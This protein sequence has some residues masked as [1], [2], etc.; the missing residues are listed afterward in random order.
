[1][2]T[3]LLALTA[4]ACTSGPGAGLRFQYGPFR[5][6]DELFPA[7]EQVKILVDGNEFTTPPCAQLDLHTL[8]PGAHAWSATAL[9]EGQTALYE[10]S[11]T[12]LV[13]QGRAASELLALAP[14]PEA[15]GTLT[16][17][18]ELPAR[19][20]ESCVYFLVAPTR[21]EL[22]LDGAQ[23]PAGICQERREVSLPTGLHTLEARVF[24]AAERLLLS[25]ARRVELLPGVNQP[26][27]VETESHVGQALVRWRLVEG[28]VERTCGQWSSER[29]VVSIVGENT[30]WEGLCES[31]QVRSPL[32]PPGDYELVLT[33]A[34]ATGRGAVHLERGRY[35]TEVS[36]DVVR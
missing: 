30:S 4:C 20:G 2:R 32:L 36:I 24:D 35:D 3:F 1:M 8:N 11:G 29:V 17:S 10:G 31:G 5:C 27:S 19:F 18:W 9:G 28:G 23:V 15:P 25:G 21:A 16:L 33:T 26:A 14:V 13:P 7:I 12:L 34:G 6:G 22:W